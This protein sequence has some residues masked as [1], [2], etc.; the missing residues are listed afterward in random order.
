MVATR[1][2]T[3][4][5]LRKQLDQMTRN[6]H[7]TDSANVKLRSTVDELK[8][9]IVEISAA[10]NMRDASRN[11]SLIGGYSLALR[12]SCS[13]AG[14]RSALAMMTG[15]ELQQNFK[16]KEIVFKFEHK[17]ATAKRLKA[18]EVYREGIVGQL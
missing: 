7:K 4:Q 6:K 17:V 18:A 1:D 14:A 5:N 16:F 10:V 3:I 11:I 8:S 2:E 9:D 12:R 15:G 13:H